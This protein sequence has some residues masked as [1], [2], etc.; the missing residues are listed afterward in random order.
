[1]PI[2]RPEHIEID[3]ED[4]VTENSGSDSISEASIESKSI[5]DMVDENKIPSRM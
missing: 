2:F 5:S 3:I 4:A 1:M